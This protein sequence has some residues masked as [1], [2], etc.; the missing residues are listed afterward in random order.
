MRRVLILCACTIS[1]SL[2]GAQVLTQHN[3]VM[4]SGVNASETLLTTS[5]V[6]PNQFGK[7]FSRAVDAE[8]Y[9]QPLYVPNLNINGI[10][11]VVFVATEG[12][13]VYAFDA[14]NASASGP[15]WSVNLGTPVLATAVDCPGNLAPQIGIT[16][17][18]VIDLST[19]TIYVDAKTTDSAGYHHKLHAL[20]LLSGSEKFG[21]PV[22][23]AASVS[24]TGSGSVGA[25]VTFNPLIQ[26]QRSGLLLNNGIVYLMFGSHCDENPYHGW[27]MGYSA[28]TL[29]Q[30]AVFLSSPNGAGAGIWQAGQGPAVDS[31][32]SLFL[33]T[34]NGTFDYNTGGSDAG[35]T[36][37]KLSSG[38]AM[39][40]YFTPNDQA[41]LDTSDRDLGSGGVLL[42]PPLPG[43]S[44]N[45]AIAGGKEGILYLLSRTSLGQFNTTDAVVQ[46][47]QAASGGIF[48]AP[49]YWNG[50]LYLWS[51]RDP[52]RQFEW[53]SGSFLT[54]A[55]HS[56]STPATF[57]G[58]ILSL[59]ANGTTPG[60]GIVWGTLGTASSGNQVVAGVLH[61]YDASNVSIE[62][63]NSYMNKARDDFGNF[64]KF[65]PPTIANGRVFIATSSNQ[66]A[67]YGLLSNLTAPGNLTAAPGAFSVRLNWT[68]STGSAGIA[69]YAIF[70]SSG[71]RTIKVATSTTTSFTDTGLNRRKYTYYVQAVDQYGN[72][73][74]PSATVTAKPR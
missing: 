38:L 11:N 7:V 28:R 56:A 2:W 35:D 25:L 54:S 24:G 46:E 20:D 4:R 47:W 57:P 53:S 32:G 61:A 15:L 13:T 30:T 34:G 52:L 70:R 64:A 8:I 39:Q 73:S 22:E 42:L 55:A 69:G 16:S 67:V 19:R 33:A 23:V 66:L 1:P 72:Y 27:V 21:G 45:L 26:N 44:A 6:N 59:S 68:A 48:S 62:L 18:P 3:D 74:V 36:V 9:A 31:N 12:N 43:T 14:D 71:T 5:N 17:T 41:Y 65:C 60:T 51:N 40:G 10:R 29:R 58:G 49:V 50:S 63:W 37:L